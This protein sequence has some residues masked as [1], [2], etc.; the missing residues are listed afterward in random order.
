MDRKR[1]SICFGKEE[2]QENAHNLR[3]SSVRGFFEQIFTISC[4]AYLQLGRPTMNTYI[5]I[6]GNSFV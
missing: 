2:T 3:A 6:L 1:G 5:I 4:R